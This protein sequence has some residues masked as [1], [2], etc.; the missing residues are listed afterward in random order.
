MEC[1]FLRMCGGGA[2]NE[3][4]SDGSQKL[5]VSSISVSNVAVCGI[6]RSETALEVQAHA[7]T[8]EWT[9]HRS[10]NPTITGLGLGVAE[11]DMGM[12]GGFQGQRVAPYQG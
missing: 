4:S 3:K 6:C 9:S 1:Q 10:D 12:V 11:C 7:D 5:V 8:V 2:R